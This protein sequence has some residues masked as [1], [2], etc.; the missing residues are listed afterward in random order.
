MPANTRTTQLKVQW[1]EVRLK[2]DQQLPGALLHSTGRQ[3]VTADRSSPPPTQGRATQIAR[4]AHRAIQ[5]RSG[6]QPIFGG[7]SGG[8]S[9]ADASSSDT[10]MHDSTIIPADASTP[11][12]SGI[13]ADSTA[14]PN[15][16]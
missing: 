10:G 5:G 15:G 13:N 14:K 16:P 1:Q 9:V 2:Y 3:R 4:N 8:L 6:A 11:G 7:G 12:A